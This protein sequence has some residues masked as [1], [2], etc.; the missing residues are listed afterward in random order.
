MTLSKHYITKADCSN[1]DCKEDA[2]MME[3]LVI[4]VLLFT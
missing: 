3:N 4:S 2:L 1:Y